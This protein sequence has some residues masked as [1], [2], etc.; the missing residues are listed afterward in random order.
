MSTNIIK[1]VSLLTVIW[2]T[3]IEGSCIYLPKSKISSFGFLLPFLSLTFTRLFYVFAKQARR[4]ACLVSLR[5]SK[6]YS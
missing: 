6:L 2:L 1:H 3:C 5:D 4:G